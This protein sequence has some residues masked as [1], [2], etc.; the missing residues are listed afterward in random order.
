MGI[1]F[2]TQCNS[3]ICDEAMRMS[4]KSLRLWESLGQLM[5]ERQSTDFPLEA[6]YIGSEM[7]D[8]GKYPCRAHSW[9]RSSLKL[10][11]SG[12][13][14]ALTEWYKNYVILLDLTVYL[15]FPLP[16]LTPLH[17]TLNKSSIDCFNNPCLLPSQLS[18]LSTSFNNDS[19]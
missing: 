4:R 14:R 2:R 5:G 12:L 18:P 10:C 19:I 3:D 17:V 15:R 7:A 13:S 9:A 8:S 6:S 1:A 16:H 11:Y